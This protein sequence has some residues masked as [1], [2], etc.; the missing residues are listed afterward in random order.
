MPLVD[1]LGDKKDNSTMDAVR[2]SDHV[3]AALRLAQYVLCSGRMRQDKESTSKRTRSAS[4]P[5]VHCFF[6]QAF[7]LSR[8]LITVSVKLQWHKSNESPQ[9][10]YCFDL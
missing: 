2:N 8:V 4:C 5:K 3:D 9:L 6:R 1:C 10:G 7:R